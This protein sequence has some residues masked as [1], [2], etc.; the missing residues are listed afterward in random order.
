MPDEESQGRNIILKLF[1]VIDVFHYHTNAKLCVFIKKSLRFH[2]LP[3]I[4]LCNLCL[5][6]WAC[7]EPTSQHPTALKYSL[8][9]ADEDTRFFFCFVFCLLDSK[10]IPSTPQP[11]NQSCLQAIFLLSNR[12]IHGCLITTMFKALK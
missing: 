9:E 10:I 1:F 6:C 4:S 5:I 12:V 8:S 3:V 11:P 7:C 2:S